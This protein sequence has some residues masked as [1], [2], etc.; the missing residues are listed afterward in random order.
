M[1]DNRRAAADYLAALT[2]AEAAAFM[3]DARGAR[4]EMREFARAVFARRD[5][6]EPAA[7][8][9]D[10]EEARRRA[11]IVPDA[12]RTPAHTQD[13]TDVRTF[14]ARLFGRPE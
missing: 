7:T 14:A 2:D 4:D 12:G 9:L 1:T 10:L 5:D 8:V 6:D 13:D 3:A 11:D